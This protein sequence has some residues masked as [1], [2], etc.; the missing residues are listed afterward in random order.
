MIFNCTFPTEAV[1]SC[2]MR[3][4]DLF[5]CYC[6]YCVLFLHGFNLLAAINIVKIIF[7]FLVVLRPN[8]GHG[9]LSLEVSG[10]RTRTHH[11]R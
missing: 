8:A 6:K 7:F 11:S 2:Q 1:T 3:R 9:L 5:F 10:S 4:N